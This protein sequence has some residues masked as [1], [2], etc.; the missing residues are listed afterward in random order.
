MNLQAVYHRT[1]NAVSNNVMSK[2]I[3]I[4]YITKKTI[5]KYYEENKYKDA[6]SNLEYPSS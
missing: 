6:H 4:L 1:I 3:H 2:R 5:N